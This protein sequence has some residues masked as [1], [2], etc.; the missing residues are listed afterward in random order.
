[1]LVDRIEY[2]AIQV[3]YSLYRGATAE[4]PVIQISFNH[5]HHDIPFTQRDSTTTVITHKV[6]R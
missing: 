3:Q 4:F 6:E 5:H 2:E 1:M